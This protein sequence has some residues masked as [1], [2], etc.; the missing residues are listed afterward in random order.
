[1]KILF[2]SAKP[3]EI[4]YLKQSNAERYE[5][6]FTEASLRSDTVHQAK[7]YDGISIFTSDDGSAT[8]QAGLKLAGVKFIAI[9]ATGYDNV[10]IKAANEHYIHVANVPDYSPYSVAEH[11]VALILALNRKICKAQ[12]KVHD[13]NFRLDDLIGFDLHKKM[14]GIVGTGKIGKV[15]AKIMNGFGCTILAHDLLED[16]ELKSKYDVHYV[17]LNTLFSLSDIISIHVP[18]TEKTQ[19]LV[20]ENSLKMMKKGVMLINSSRGA[21]INTNDLIKYIE[22]GHIGY[23]GL[24]VYEKEKGLFFHDHSKKKIEDPL[25][26]KLIQ[27]RNVL[28]TPHQAFVTRE[29]LTNIASTTFDNIHGWQTKDKAANELTDPSSWKKYKARA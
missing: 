3:F 10:D 29:A 7:G 22:N 21:I 5:I 17:G 11:T 6:D 28:V 23:C 2:Y 20:D 13:Y 27:F 4:P 14:V 24:D 19:Y 25:F 1:M 8:V 26:E 15:F 12:K 9:R 18:L 16:P